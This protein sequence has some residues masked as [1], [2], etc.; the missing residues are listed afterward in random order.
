MIP[1]MSYATIRFEVAD[2]VATL[3]LNR[4]DKLNSFTAEMHAELK[5]A[6]GRVAAADSGVRALLITGAGR[7]FCAGQDLSQRAGPV[8]PDLGETIEKQ[9]NPLIRTLRTLE[10]PVIGAVNGTAA[11]AGMSLALACDITLAARSASFLQ[12]FAKIGLIPDA[13]STFF[14]PRLAG[15]ARARGL[16]MLAD[17]IG[18]EQAAAWGLIWKVVDDDKLLPEATALA[19]HLAV[20]PTR[21]LA[22]IKQALNRSAANDLDRQLDVERDL[23]R[24]AGR[25]EDYREGVA[26]FFEKRAPRF[27][28]R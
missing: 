28:G 15:E 11:G 27:K 2:Q 8:V 26:A 3:T 9:F 19:R 10:I 14:L 4:P 25:T 20:Q 1:I 21:G 16:A 5:D 23:Q 18:A 24:I 7:G 12:A 17:K 22:L 13:G 6:L